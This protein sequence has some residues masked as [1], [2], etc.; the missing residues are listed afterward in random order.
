MAFEVITVAERG[1]APR[2]ASEPRCKI[3]NRQTGS[4]RRGGAPKT[5]TVSTGAEH[6]SDH[7]KRCDLSLATVGERRLPITPSTTLVLDHHHQ[8]AVGSE[9]FNGGGAMEASQRKAGQQS[10]D[11]SVKVGDFGVV[12]IK[13][14]PG[15]GML[16]YYAY[17]EVGGSTVCCIDYQ[18][19]L[20]VVYGVRTSDMRK[21]RPELARKWFLK[22]HVVA[23][24]GMVDE[25]GW[26]LRP[27]EEWPGHRKVRLY[28]WGVVRI[29]RGWSIGRLGYY[30]DDEHDDDGHA[31]AIVYATDMSTADGY[32]MIS[33]R[34]LRIP[35]PAQ[36]R[37]WLAKHMPADNKMIRWHLR[38][39]EQPD[40]AK[41][42]R[43]GKAKRKE[44]L[45]VI[46]GGKKPDE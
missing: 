30:D 4:F 19:A 10:I 27:E 31:K 3:V 5:T 44:K 25:I 18:G 22:N 28:E 34:D 12:L 6:R 38:G 24:L 36:A 45:T 9:P 15:A 46:D 35:T 41:P 2:L 29:A 1:G 14:G 20:E 13:D 26:K 43:K 23:S 42:T 21:V 37:R 40:A 16:G 33:R 17:D 8:L 32:W 7:E 39:D 11:T